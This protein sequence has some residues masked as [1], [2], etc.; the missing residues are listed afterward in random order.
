MLL[1]GL[2]GFLAPVSLAAQKTDVVVIANGDVITGEI[3]GLSRGK[4]DYNTDDAG[5]LSIK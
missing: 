3:K 1:L 2:S 4:L 5:R